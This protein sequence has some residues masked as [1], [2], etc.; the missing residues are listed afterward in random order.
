MLLLPKMHRLFGLCRTLHF[1]RRQLDLKKISPISPHQQQQ[2]T[3]RLLLYLLLYSFFLSFFLYL[4][5]LYISLLLVVCWSF[6]GRSLVTRWS[7]VGLLLVVSPVVS[8]DACVIFALVF[9]TVYDNYCTSES[10]H[11]AG[12]FVGRFQRIQPHITFRA[13]TQKYVL[14]A[15]RNWSMK[16]RLNAAILFCS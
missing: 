12:H 16:M 15:N 10:G 14:T 8:L 7:F 9:I 4:F 3:A 5:I 1:I 13:Q 2:K 11:S 6:A